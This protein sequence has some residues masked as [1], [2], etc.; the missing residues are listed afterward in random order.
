MIDPAGDYRTAL[1]NRPDYQA[2]RLGITINRANAQAAHNGLLPQVNLSWSYGYNG[3]NTS[4]AAARRMAASQDFPSSSIGLSLS[5]PITNAQGRGRAR[6]AR[7]T[8]E[9]SEADLRRLEAD[10]AVAVANAASQVETARQ[11]VAAD[12]AAYDLANRALADEVKKLRESKST[13]LSVIQA[14]GYLITVETSVASALNAERQATANYDAQLGTILQRY[15]ITL[16][17][18]R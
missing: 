4:F 3:L 5:I 13:T 6:A 2:A 18:I 8:L 12:R 17:A 9:Q 1:N 15:N 7:L 14:Q 11:R 10:I 16:D